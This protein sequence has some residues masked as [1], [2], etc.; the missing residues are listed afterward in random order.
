MERHRPVLAKSESARADWT[1]GRLHAVFVAARFLDRLRPAPCAVT[2]VRDRQVCSFLDVCG[3]RHRD[4]HGGLSNLFA[5]F[6]IASR[7]GLFSNLAGDTSL[8]HDHIGA[9]FAQ[10]TAYTAEGDSWPGT[11]TKAVP[12]DRTDSYSAI[13][14]R[15]V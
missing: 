7:I 12:S 14:S 2:Y 13:V 15:T 1:N 11:Q 3:S 9:C 8:P 5:P 10:N 4:R 6:L